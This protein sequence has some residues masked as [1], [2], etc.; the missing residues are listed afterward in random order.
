MDALQSRAFAGDKRYG[1]FRHK[2]RVGEERQE[3]GIGRPLARRGPDARR[4]DLAAVR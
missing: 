2:Q 3:R 4:K 1:R